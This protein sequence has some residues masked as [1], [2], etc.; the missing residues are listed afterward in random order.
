[1]IGMQPVT[2]SSP[3][4]CTITSQHIYRAV[5][6]MAPTLRIF[7]DIQLT[8]ML[9]RLTA[10][11]QYRTRTVFRRM[12]GRARSGRNDRGCKLPTDAATYYYVL[13]NKKCDGQY[14]SFNV[15]VAMEMYHYNNGHLHGIHVVQ[16]YDGCRAKTLYM[17]GKRHGKSLC[18]YAYGVPAEECHYVNGL[19]DGV[20]RTWYR[21]GNIAAEV[22]YAAGVRHGLCR[23][24]HDSGMQ[25][26]TD[27]YA[28]G[29][30]V[31]DAAN[32]KK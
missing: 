27:E 14:L 32:A 11:D 12:V 9:C 6:I 4:L 23:Y 16:R 28:N 29:E 15:D 8:Y 7:R 24:W 20:T 18:W 26:D 10:S 3:I 1:M 5:A 2:T 19:R 22:Q 31:V 13:P 30:L 21:N 17:H 25:L